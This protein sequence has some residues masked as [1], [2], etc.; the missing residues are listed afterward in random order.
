MHNIQIEGAESTDQAED[1]QCKR[2][3][4][5]ATSYVLE[6]NAELYRRLTDARSHTERST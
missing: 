1:S 3:F 5:E 6:K 2:E 4:A